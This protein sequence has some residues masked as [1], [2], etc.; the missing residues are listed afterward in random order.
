MEWKLKPQQNV[1]MMIAVCAHAVVKAQ[2]H[3]LNFLLQLQL[4]LHHQDAALDITETAIHNVFQ[5]F[6]LIHCLQIV[7]QAFQLM[8]LETV[9]HQQAQFHVHLDLLKEA[10]LVFQLIQVIHQ[11]QLVALKDKKQMDM[12]IVF[13]Q[14]FQIFAIQ[15]IKVMEADPAFQIL[16]QYLQFAHQDIQVMEQVDAFPMIHF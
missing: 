1:V 3:L 13:Q 6:F 16:F 12:E 8:D 7:H 14:Q 4:H 10:E 5:I 15:D 11:H 9:Y 2:L